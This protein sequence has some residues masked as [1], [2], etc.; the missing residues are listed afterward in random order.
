MKKILVCPIVIGVLIAIY[1]ANNKSETYSILSLIDIESLAYGE[2]G[3]DGVCTTTTTFSLEWQ[4]CNGQDMPLRSITSN[5]CEGTGQEECFN[6]NK[7][8]FYDCEGQHT[9]T[10]DYV[11]R[12]HCK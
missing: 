11:Q 7:Y 5:K 4:K 9:S 1:V 3:T 6:G 10:N 2:S 12:A 8:V